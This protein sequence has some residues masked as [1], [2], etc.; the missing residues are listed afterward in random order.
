MTTNSCKQHL[1][2]DKAGAVTTLTHDDLCDFHL[3]SRHRHHRRDPTTF[4]V[5][6]RGS[7]THVVV[8]QSLDVCL[9]VIRDAIQ[10]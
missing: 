7:Y 10:T 4:N 2:E 3:R 5:L 8:S 6:K 9:V 1:K